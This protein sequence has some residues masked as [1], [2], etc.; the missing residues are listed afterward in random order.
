M[1]VFE[2]LVPLLLEL[3][4]QLPFARNERV[5][6]QLN[7]FQILRESLYEQ[8]LRGLIRGGIECNAQFPMLALL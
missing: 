4:L 7:R 2:S 3:G 6:Q 1:M 8:G 5:D